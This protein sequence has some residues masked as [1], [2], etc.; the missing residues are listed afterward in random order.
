M[1]RESVYKKQYKIS[2]IEFFWGLP[3]FVAMLISAFLSNSLL[4]WLDAVD[5]S[6]NAAN[7]GFATIISKRLTKNLKYKYNY[8]VEKV[9]AL[10][11]LLI[12]TFEL[13]SVM[14]IFVLSL[15]E[16]ISP[17]Q[18]SNLLLLPILIKIINI[19]FNVTVLIKQKQLKNNVETKL[20]QTEYTSSVKNV[21]FGSVTFVSIFV[22]WLFREY[23]FSWYF[24]PVMCIIIVLY[25][26]YHSVSEIIKSI[27][28]LT[29]KTLP[30]EE[31]MK[32]LKCLTEFY[33][34]YTELISVNSLVRGNTNYIELHL[35]FESEMTFEQIE[36]FKRQISD[37]LKENMT[38]CKIRIVI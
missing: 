31:Q 20:I 8:G 24:S 6:I 29:E 13:F 37:R 26:I 32:I 19:I 30:E 38:D 28:E 4:V 22:C 10:S 23:R 18:P 9:E 16:I 14:I 7:I 25:I 12:G 34:Q 36:N 15:V 2:L 21:L 27:S 5:S 3:N 1:K 11:A 33:S 35:N 17:E